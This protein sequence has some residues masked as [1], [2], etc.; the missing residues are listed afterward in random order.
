MKKDKSRLFKDLKVYNLIMSNI[1][2]LVTILLIGVLAGYL[3]EKNAEDKS[4]NYMLFSIIFFTVIGI[5]NFFVSIIKGSKR[6]EKEE[7]KKALA[8]KQL[9]EKEEQSVEKNNDDTI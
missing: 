2:Q 6:L 1:W 3:F 9:E 8:R 4:I 5:I 7:A